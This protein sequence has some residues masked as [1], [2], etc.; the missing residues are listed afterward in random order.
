MTLLFPRS[1]K[2]SQPTGI[3][4]A[5]GSGPRKGTGL[6]SIHETFLSRLASQSEVVPP[7]V[8]GL[9]HASGIMNKDDPSR[10]QSPAIARQRSTIRCPQHLS[11]APRPAVTSLRQRRGRSLATIGSVLAPLGSFPHQG[12]EVLPSPLGQSGRDKGACPDDRLRMAQ[13]FPV[14]RTISVQR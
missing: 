12:L 3:H 5:Q 1:H 4:A 13:F 8:E 10:P 11:P 9:I 6:R 7:W 14:S 2:P